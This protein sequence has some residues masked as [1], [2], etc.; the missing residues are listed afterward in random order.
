MERIK[1]HTIED[2]HNDILSMY[3]VNI[4]DI[5]SDIY[6]KLINDKLFVSQMK[7]SLNSRQSLYDVY[8]YKIDNLTLQLIDLDKSEYCMLK[9]NIMCSDTVFYDKWKN[10]L[11]DFIYTELAGK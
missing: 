1:L 2:K 11:F 7:Q 6:K 10:E 4:C 8:N 9:Y 5:I 3:G